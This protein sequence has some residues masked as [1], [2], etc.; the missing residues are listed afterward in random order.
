MLVVHAHCHPVAFEEACALIP[1]HAGEVVFRAEIA[2]GG[3]GRVGGAVI[4]LVDAEVCVGAHGS[5]RAV[6]VV[7]HGCRY[8]SAGDPLVGIV[9]RAA[10]RSGVG[11]VEMGD[12][13]IHI[14]FP[15]GIEVVTQFQVAAI[16][17]ESHAGAVVVGAVI[18]GSGGGG[19]FSAAHLGACLCL[20][21]S[22]TAGAHVDVRAPSV[23]LHAT[24]HDVHHTAHGV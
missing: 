23:G 3:F 22:I 9:E 6:V 5:R 1:R 2:L 11:G 14:G 15:V 24:G 20:H 16:L 8:H 10:H 21:R 13:C 7:L 17:L 19:E 12:V 4:N 18:L